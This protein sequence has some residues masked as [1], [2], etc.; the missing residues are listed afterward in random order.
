MLA[1]VLTDIFIRCASILPRVTTSLSVGFVAVAL[2]MARPLDVLLLAPTRL[3]RILN[4]RLLLHLV[5]VRLPPRLTLLKPSFVSTWSS[6]LRGS[7][8]PFGHP[9]L[10]RQDLALIPPP[11]KLGFKSVSLG[12]SLTRSE[13]HT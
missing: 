6:N 5:I 3:V 2:R 4:F 1:L 8:L 13:E 10:D 11:L 9:D 12:G 7:P